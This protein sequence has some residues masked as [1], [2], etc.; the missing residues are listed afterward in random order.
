[1]QLPGVKSFFRVLSFVS[2]HSSRSPTKWR[3]QKILGEAGS[4]APDNPFFVRKIRCE[5]IW[6]ENFLLAPLRGDEVLLTTRARRRSR[7]VAKNQFL[8][9]H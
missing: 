5:V 1:M 9:H 7:H 2:Y 3:T 4:A 6:R 8:G